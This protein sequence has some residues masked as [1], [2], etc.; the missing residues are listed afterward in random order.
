MGS[1]A[2]ESM[3]RNAAQHACARHGAIVVILGHQHAGGP[4]TAGVL[5]LAVGGDLFARNFVTSLAWPGCNV[6]CLAW[7]LGVL[8]GTRGATASDHM[9]AV[10]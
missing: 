1:G 6:S 10:I 4:P 2:C 9:N 8:A 5:A 3:G 7:V